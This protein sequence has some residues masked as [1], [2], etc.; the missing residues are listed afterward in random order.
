MGCSQS[1][2]EKK[3]TGTGFIQIEL[4]IAQNETARTLS[5]AQAASAADYYSVYIHGGGYGYSSE[6]NVSGNRIALPVGSYVVVVLAG[7]IYGAYTYLC[8]SGY[9][10]SVVVEANKTTNVEI[11]LEVPTLEIDYLAETLTLYPDYSEDL[12]L[13]TFRFDSHNPYVSLNSLGMMYDYYRNDSAVVVNREWFPSFQEAEAYLATINETYSVENVSWPAAVGEYCYGYAGGSPVVVL[14]NGRPITT[15]TR[16]Y[17]LGPLGIDDYDV[18]FES[19][20]FEIKQYPT[21]INLQL[22]WKSD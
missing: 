1:T 22:S 2:I 5:N 18:L 7:R 21:G 15:D 20:K 19:H 3:D 17:S 11:E 6:L 13:F 10:E 14:Y 8:G 12:P 16:G 9:A 4:P